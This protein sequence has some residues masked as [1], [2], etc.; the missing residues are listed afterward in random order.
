M[1]TTCEVRYAL[2]PHDRVTLFG[3]VQSISADR[4]QSSDTIMTTLHHIELT[5]PICENRFRSQTVM[6]TNA[7]GGKRTDFHERA[8]GMQ[9]LPYFV[10][11]CNRCG[12]TGAERDFTE[13]VE[14]SRPHPR[15]R[16]ERARARAQARA[17]RQA[18]SSTRPPRRWPTGRGWSRAT[19]PTC[20]CAP[21][22]C[23]VDEG[24]IEAERSSAARRRGC[25]EAL[26]IVRRRAAGGARGAHLPGGRA[27]APRRRRGLAQPGS[28]ACRKRSPSRS[29]RHGW[30][31]RRSSSGRSPGSGFRE[32]GSWGSAGSRLKLKKL[33]S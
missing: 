14:P 28:T 10:H 18:R 11:M 29:R 7:F 26:L 33:G 2:T 6:P 20:C 25:F 31:R 8:A 19:S 24:D 32:W 9:P 4:A 22:W 16:V 17:R 1:W 27:V 15:E 13:E 23:C 21:R 5:C 12:Y 3:S 30:W